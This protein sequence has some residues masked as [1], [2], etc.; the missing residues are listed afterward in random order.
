MAYL[1][2]HFGEVS[3]LALSP[4]DRGFSFADGL[5]EAVRA[6]QG[7]WFRMEEHLARLDRGAQFL[8]LNQTTLPPL[9]EIADTLLG[10]NNL[11]GQDALFYL[12]IS[13]G[14]APRAHAFP[15][16]ET[17]LT[18]FAFV[19]PFSSK[20]EEMQQ[21]I[22]AVSVADIRWLRCDI[23]T[24]ALTA[25]ILAH[26]EAIDRGAR[27]A[28]FVRDGRITEGSHTNC[29]GV[30]DGVLFTHPA[31]HLVLSGVNRQVVLQICRREGFPVREEA[32]T[33]AEALEVEELFVTGTTTDV[34]PV[35]RLDGQ[36]VGNGLP[37]PVTRFMQEKFR[38]ETRSIL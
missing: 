1:N 27:E 25:S 38:D 14:V 33:M 6:Y 28:L 35:V 32:F 11:D 2:G 23:K 8:R 18:C 10:L 3:Q 37:G 15:N 12:Q 9:A 5:Y 36:T 17:A 4:L 20:V 29:F 7:V 19:K 22:A 16:P 34:T 24:T 26:Q 13:R 30:R 21:G 31:N